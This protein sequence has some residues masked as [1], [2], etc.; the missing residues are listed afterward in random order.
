MENKERERSW[1]TASKY[2]GVYVLDL[3]TNLSFPAYHVSLQMT[4]WH[5][6]LAHLSDANLRQLRNKPP[7]FKMDNHESPTIPTYKGE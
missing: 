1:Y 5:H 4:L 3:W 7:A 2:H 6:Q